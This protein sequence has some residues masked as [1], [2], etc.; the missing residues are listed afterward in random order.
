MSKIPS[1]AEVVHSYEDGSILNVILDLIAE[2]LQDSEWLKKF[3]THTSSTSDENVHTITWRWNIEGVY[4]TE[5]TI[6]MIKRNLES[7]GWIDVA[8]SKFES[9]QDGKMLSISISTLDQ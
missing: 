2:K 4:P 1:P 8:I 9:R 6:R 3:A 5:N 7:Q